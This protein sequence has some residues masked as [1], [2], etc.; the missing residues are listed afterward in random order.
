MN[1]YVLDGKLH[2]GEKRVFLESDVDET[3]NLV[4]TWLDQ[5]IDNIPENSKVSITI[6]VMD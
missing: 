3:G 1:K 5:V 2:K 6:E 4:G